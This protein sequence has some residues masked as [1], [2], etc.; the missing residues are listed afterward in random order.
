MMISLLPLSVLA[1]NT[2][3][4]YTWD[5]PPPSK[6]FPEKDLIKSSKLN[7]T[8]KTFVVYREGIGGR[9]DCDTLTFENGAFTSESDKKYGFINCPYS[10]KDQG[11]VIGLKSQCQSEAEGALDWSAIVNGDM[12]QGTFLWKKDGQPDREYQFTGSLLRKSQD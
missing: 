7:F 8:G 5:T 6:T 9:T 12:I 3:V 11:N 2:T 1:Q 4:E 10:A